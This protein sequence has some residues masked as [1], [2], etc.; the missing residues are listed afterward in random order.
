MSEIDQ[1]QSK[2]DMIIE[3]LHLIKI[4]MAKNNEAEKNHRANSARFWEQT[5]P[6]VVQQ[7]SENRR[8]IADQN[9]Q[10][11]RLTTKMMMFGTGLVI[12][13]PILSTLIFWIIDKK[14]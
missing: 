13:T 9:I 1:L 6:E 8:A 4:E 11:A 2:I 7:I 14:N 5:W 10:I 12:M 3:E